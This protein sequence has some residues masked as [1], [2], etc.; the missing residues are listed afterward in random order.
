LH[1]S[2]CAPCVL[3]HLV[4]AVFFLVYDIGSF[5][6]LIQLALLALEAFVCDLRLPFF[7]SLS[8]SQR[9]ECVS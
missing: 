7:L 6:F 9:A 1:V 8:L 3:V 5:L 2:S 4:L